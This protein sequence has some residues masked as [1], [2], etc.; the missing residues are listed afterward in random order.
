M[1]LRRSPLRTAALVATN[2]SNARRSTG[3]RTA[4][5]KRES[6]LNALKH[7]RNS[8]K[9]GV[10]LSGSAAQE[11]HQLRQALWDAIVPTSGPEQEAV[12]RFAC[13]VWTARREV[14]RRIA[15][16]AGRALHFGPSGAFPIP[17]RA[18][19]RRRGWKVCVSVW[20]R[21]GRGRQGQR[22]ARPAYG[23]QEGQ[24]R[25][26]AMV[27]V[28]ASMRHPG[29]RLHRGPSGYMVPRVVFKTKPECSRNC[30]ASKY[31]IALRN[32]SV[33]AGQPTPR[34]ARSR[35]F[36]GHQSSSASASPISAAL[37]PAPAAGR[38]ALRRTLGAVLGKLWGAI[39]GG[40]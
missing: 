11:F 8:G 4:E 13:N 37:A 34:R 27:T 21:R 6:A 19:A 30:R 20:L 17:F 5:G 16:P 28:T 40:G 18:R 39:R 26:H 7:G 24:G 25:L 32:S 35:L 29:Y 3:P 33:A 23:W 1:C 2:R 12:N 10:L 36:P 14:E 22:M 15:S 38:P 9:L 31:N